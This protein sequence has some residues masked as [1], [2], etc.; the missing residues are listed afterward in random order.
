[1]DYNQR[2]R[3]AP[4]AQRKLA[5]G[6]ASP[7]A[8]TTGPEKKTIPP[9]QGR[10]NPASIKVPSPLPGRIALRDW[11]RWFALADSL[12]HRLISLVPPA[13]VPA[14]LCVVHPAVSSV[15]AKT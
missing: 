14:T 3:N 15:S 12:H 9:R 13:P 10:G 5:G 1:M 2:P 8:R 6:E 4:E 7:R 11:F